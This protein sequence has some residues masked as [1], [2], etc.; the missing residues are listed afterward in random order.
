MISSQLQLIASHC[1]SSE[2]IV[3]NT[4]NA[5]LSNQLFI[6]KMISRRSINSQIDI[7]VN[8]TRRDAITEQNFNRQITTQVALKQS[9]LFSASSS[10]F[11]YMNI[12]NSSQGYYFAK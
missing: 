12:D 1:H 11:L 6:P 9:L 8:E 7:L 4:L 3:T 10:S 5:L 2:V